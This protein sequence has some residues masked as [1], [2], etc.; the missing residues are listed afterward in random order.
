M[1][2]LGFREDP[3]GKAPA[4][5]LGEEVLALHGELPGAGSPAS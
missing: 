3:G 1:C 2:P 4:R 5:L